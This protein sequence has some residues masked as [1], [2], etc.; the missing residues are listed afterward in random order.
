MKDL[1]NQELINLPF[2]WYTKL[3]QLSIEA[4]GRTSPNPAVACIITKGKKILAYGATEPLGQRHSEVVAIDS[5]LSLYK[6]QLENFKNQIYLIVTLEPCST[7]GKTPPCTLKIKTLK[8]YIKTIIV[9][10]YDINLNKSGFYYL[11]NEGFDI[12][13]KEIFR[14][15]HF[16]LHSFY[17]VVKKKSHN[18]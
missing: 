1:D 4:I 3:W 17:N 5:F 15:P 13:K 10:N 9:E 2:E 11:I 18:I 8:P 7:Y 14:K 6:D 16:A 12:K